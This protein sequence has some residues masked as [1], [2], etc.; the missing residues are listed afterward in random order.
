MEDRKL[1]SVQRILKIEPIKDRDRIELATIQGWKV[2]VGKGEFKER[3]LCV[4]IQYDTILP[5][6]EPFEFLRSRCYSP[7]WKGFRIRNMKMAGVFSQ[8]IVFSI[9]V[10]P[11]TCMKLLHEGSDVTEILQIRKYDPELK[12][13]ITNIP[14]NKFVKFFR[15]LFGIKKKK[16]NVS[17]PAD[18]NKADEKNIQ[19]VYNDMLILTES[20]GRSGGYPDDWI[21][22]EKLE[23]QAAT[24]EYRVNKGLFKRNTFNV[25]SHNVR[26]PKP[27]NSNWW[28]I[29]DM[30]AIKENL[31]NECLRCDMDISLQGEI[32]GPGIQKNVY[33][34]KGLRFYV[35]SITI[36]KKYKMLQKRKIEFSTL[37]ALCKKLHLQT[38]PFI[39]ESTLRKFHDVDG[40]LKHSNGKSLLNDEQ[41][42]EGCVWSNKYYPALSFKAK[43]SDY[44]MWWEKKCVKDEL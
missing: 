2:I 36:L 22:T 17:Y 1:A 27:D 12:L 43:S 20:D 34:L 37:K 3:D 7:K 26:H 8:G 29:A 33:G 32:V 11:K 15:K 14:E 41:I 6:W 25:Y 28:K 10:I 44:L 9:K 5:E 13:E 23:G 16:Y 38:V 24:F 21:L 18:I 39:E 19:V 40:I 4:Y 30:Y 31:K 35:Y 42:R